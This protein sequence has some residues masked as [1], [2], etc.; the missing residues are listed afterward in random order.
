[1]CIS[2]CQGCKVYI[3]IQKFFQYLEVTDI[4]NTNNLVQA[5][6]FRLR[7]F[8]YLLRIQYLI[9]SIN[10]K[11]IVYLSCLLLCQTSREVFFTV[12]FFRS[13]SKMESI[14]CSSLQNDKR[15][16]TVFR[17]GANCL[18]KSFSVSY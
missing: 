2:R 11:D 16:I 8:Y 6:L 15:A 3:T 5:V 7:F 9:I 4:L 1:M 10:V 12:F 14:K 13:K 18:C 17:N